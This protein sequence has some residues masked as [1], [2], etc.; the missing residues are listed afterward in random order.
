[1]KSSNQLRSKLSIA[2]GL[3]SAKHGVSHWWLQRVT[4][5]ALIPL[6]LWFVYSVVNV[7]LSTN[8]TEVAVWFSSPVNALLFSL[9]MVAT[10][11]HAKLGLQVI[12]ED[13]VKAP[14]AKYTLLL[15]NTFFCVAAALFTV[16]AILKLHFLDV[17]GSAGG[18]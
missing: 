4:A 1:M 7:L 9:T 17:T 15:A 18:F 5:V 12:I 10:F 2:R 6:S 8:I 14:V 16:I 11:W 3:G 13:Y